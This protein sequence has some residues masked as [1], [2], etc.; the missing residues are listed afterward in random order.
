MAAHYIKEMRVGGLGI[1]L[2]KTLMDEIDY[3][4]EPGAK[5]KGVETGAYFFLAHCR[6]DDCTG[7]SKI[8]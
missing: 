2:M 6:S 7:P 5:N 4:I 1:Y 8:Y 3:E